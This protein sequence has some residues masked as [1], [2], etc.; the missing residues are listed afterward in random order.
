MVWLWLW[1]GSLFLEQLEGC[2]CNYPF[3]FPSTHWIANSEGWMKAV[4]ECAQCELAHVTPTYEFSSTKWWFTFL[5]SDTPSP[6]SW[7]RTL[8]WWRLE[9]CAMDTCDHNNKVTGGCVYCGHE[10]VNKVACQ[11]SSGAVHCLC[12]ILARSRLPAN[13]PHS[14]LCDYGVSKTGYNKQ[15]SGAW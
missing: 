12:S 15:C 6:I 9:T 5:L 8:I 4:P 7:V 2:K 1:K 10:V 3:V 11:P 14:S 13:E